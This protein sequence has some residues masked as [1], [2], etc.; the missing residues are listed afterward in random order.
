MILIKIKIIE[1]IKV[2]ITNNKICNKLTITNNR[3]INTRIII[4]ISKIYHQETLIIRIVQ[5]EDDHQV[6]KKY[7]KQETH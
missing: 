1:D 4:S 6:D 7:N 5:T 3:G 2:V